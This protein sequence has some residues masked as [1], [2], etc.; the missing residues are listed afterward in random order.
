MTLIPEFVPREADE[1]LFSRDIDGQL[2]RLDAATESEYDKRVTVFVDGQPVELPI[3]EPLKDAQGNDVLDA[4]G[5]TTPR[6]TTILNAVAALNDERRKRNEKEVSIPTLCHQSH[7]TPVA[8]CRLCMVQVK[9]AGVAERRLLPAC[10]HLVK[11]S[12]GA[13]EV[14]TM[15]APGDE[16]AR[17]RK[18]V[19]VMTE[20][21]MADHL[22]SPQD[23]V[24]NELQQ[25]AD[26]FGLSDSRFALDVLA[27]GS[28]PPPIAGPPAGHR[29]LDSSSPVF[30]VDHSACILCER[31]I[32]S[33]ND[34][35]NNYVIGRTGKGRTAGIG[36]DLNVPMFDSSCVQCGEC[37][38]SCPTSAITFKPLGAVR[39]QAGRKIEAVPLAEL[40]Q[41]PLFAGIPFKFLLWQKDLVVRRRLKRGDILCRQGDPGNSAFIIKQGRLQIVQHGSGT[42]QPI[43]RTVD[44]VIVGEMACLSG[45]P[46]NAD[47]SAMDDDSEV[48]EVRR[49]VLDRMM[50]SPGQRQKF[51]RLYRERALMG[52]LGASELFRDLAPEE[53]ARCISFLQPKVTFVRVEPGQTIL[54]Q[55]DLADCLYL[56]RLGHVRIE[57]HWLG[58]EETFI[59]GRGKVLGEMGLLS[60]SA[61][62]IG[63][64]VEEIYNTFRLNP[65]AP[66]RRNATCIALDH[67]ELLRV[68]R[69]VFIEMA[70][71]FPT[72]LRNLIT[73]SLYVL[74]ESPLPHMRTFIERGLYQGQ[75]L[76]VLDLTKC[77][78]CDECTKAC[79]RQHGTASHGHEISRL[80]REGRQFGD[81]LVATACRSCIDA[82]CM[83]GCPVDAIHRGKHLQIV[84]EDHCIGCGL[85]AR[86]C[87]YGNISMQPNL[88]AIMQAGG[89]DGPGSVRMVA[90]QKAATC[91][92]CDAEGREDHPTPRC[93]Y[94]CPH[95]AAH[96]M[97]GE[98]LLNRVEKQ[99]GES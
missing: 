63:K 78:R 44:D 17:V 55:G 46:R 76:L 81:F 67:V 42:A 62:D 8:V 71:Q 35:K 84:I 34:V 45:S 53:Y 11:D 26:R 18:A 29:L 89:D 41:D 10:Q 86:N 50:R 75:S 82:Y 2:V 12:K 14:F 97:T 60:I 6:Y 98:E 36:F 4:A 68:G 72:F 15:D 57:K 43:P 7:L 25:M 65:F 94:A 92:L 30:L 19:R 49:N 80:L 32:R 59:Y 21:L 87:P 85:C 70:R 23:P 56:I 16:G 99:Y 66:G 40:K 9:K 95:D 39:S 74:R 48:W 69:D 27:D 13:M 58:E 38:I 73:K 91:D 52:T 22:K 64:P 54:R 31:C 51:Q 37:M 20:L 33:C 90:Q 96:R 61:E 79:A 5:C 28:T 47:I 1:G 77:T 93:V 24:F 88:L 3:A 83:I